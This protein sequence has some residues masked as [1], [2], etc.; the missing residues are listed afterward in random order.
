LLLR[1][2]STCAET[3]KRAAYERKPA[4]RGIFVQGE[5]CPWPWSCQD[6]CQ[7][8]RQ[9]H[10]GTMQG[11]CCSTFVNLCITFLTVKMN[12]CQRLA[13]MG[14]E[15]LTWVGL[16][17]VAFRSVDSSESGETPVYSSSVPWLWQRNIISIAYILHCTR[18]HTRLTPK[19]SQRTGAVLCTAT[20]LG[21]T[22][23]GS[24][25]HAG[26]AQE[27]DQCPRQQS[28]DCQDLDAYWSTADKKRANNT[29]SNSLGPRDARIVCPAFRTALVVE[30]GGQD[31]TTQH[32]TGG[33]ASCR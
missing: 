4:I 29:S 8:I 21:R 33:L 27:S 32:L 28:R 11:G 2:A 23:V 25:L 9:K 30:A 5:T 31:S 10:S 7:S 22:Q 6:A 18:L 17:V 1:L 15:K 3:R 16:A 20:Y 14:R 19:H 24:S 13:V 12:Y 26:R